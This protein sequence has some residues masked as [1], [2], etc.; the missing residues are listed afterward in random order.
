M[1]RIG[2]V[3]FISFSL[4]MIMTQFNNCDTY[5]N[6]ALSYG[7]LSSLEDDE[8]ND[9]Y[10]IELEI[11]NFS[12]VELNSDSNFDISGGCYVGDFD[13]NLIEWKLLDPQG[14]VVSQNQSGDEAPHCIDGRFILSI[15]VPESFD[16]SERYNLE[17]ELV[18]L[19][20]SGKEYRNPS[21]ARKLIE[22]KASEL[23]FKLNLQ[24]LGGTASQQTTVGSATTF[25]ASG[26][27]YEGNSGGHRIRWE[28]VGFSSGGIVSM[29][30][31]DDDTTDNGVCVNGE[32]TSVI[33]LPA[34][35]PT[36][37]YTLLVEL[38][39]ISSSGVEFRNPSDM[40]VDSVALNVI[41][42]P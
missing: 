30:I 9:S 17:V 13:G 33:T 40:A 12:P 1:R 6:A 3:L 28:V 37:V 4:L 18:S 42:S 20:S 41:L 34:G 23:Y 22:V 11:Y 14:A 24:D 29:S 15:G 35:L 36:G 7:D 32:F 8:F 25:N 5:T 10:S 27:C 19:D 26:T 21:I 38:I 39:S 31:N 16:P 2:F